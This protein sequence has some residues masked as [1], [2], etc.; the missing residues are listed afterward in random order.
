M[1]AILV[2]IPAALAGCVSRE[3]LDAFVYEPPPE[4]PVDPGAP[5]VDKHLLSEAIK[6]VV[7]EHLNIT[8]L[9]FDDIP[10]VADVWKPAGDGPFPVIVILSPYFQE[11]KD[12][13]RDNKPD[14]GIYGGTIDQYV[15]RGYAVALV[16]L[17]GTRFSD[18]CMDLLGP[19][20]QRDAYEVVEY[21][22]AQPWSNGKV[23]MI[24]GSYDG[25][26]QQMAAVM[27]PEH[28]AAIVPIA[29]VADWYHVMG[30][31][32]AKFQGWMPNTPYLYNFA[33]GMGLPEDPAAI[34]FWLPEAIP[35]S[36]D[37]PRVARLNDQSCAVENQVWADDPTGDYNDWMKERDL[38]ARA[39]EATAPMLYLHG[40]VDVN[41]RP[42]HVDPWFT[43]YAGPKRAFLWQ[44]DHSAGFQAQGTGRNDIGRVVHQWLDHHL[45]G[46]QNGIETTY[47]QVEVQ[48]SLG[49]WR[50]ESAWPPADAE[51]VEFFLSE[52]AL[53]RGAP[54]EGSQLWT[55]DPF[56]EGGPIGT[57]SAAV[58]EPS[59]SRL[60]FRSA[61]LEEPLHVVGRPAVRANL[62]SDRPNTLVVVRLYDILADGSWV[63]VNEGVH[64]LRHRDGVE[65]PQA[66]QPGIPYTLVAE[67]QPADYVFQAGRR[68]GLTITSSDASYVHPSGT[69]ATNTIA[70]GG[71]EAS[72]LVFRTV[73]RDTFTQT[74]WGNAQPAWMGPRAWG[75]SG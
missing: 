2:V 48:D 54:G 30:K 47:G 50:V 28:L 24:G 71:Q 53:D 74:T 41:A 19:N 15:P 22:G 6:D 60:T 38:R 18:G 42:D 45:L 59:A 3:S 44:A 73:Q 68:I 40:F 67:I 31:G 8:I 39:A 7:V 13:L 26:T 32:G 61:P 11:A 75:A 23:G 17:R 21:F 14:G 35:P 70:Y 57:K 36:V 56:E 66:A 51:T 65:N 63:L 10:L 37:D 25:A 12:P 1:L 58:G 20:E 34:P 46:L 9:S 4:K 33:I 5:K 64:S 55:D 72:A 43:N 49:R 62:E 69:M 29:P 27:R 16:D 52:G